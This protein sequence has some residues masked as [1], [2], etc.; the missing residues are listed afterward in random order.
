[1]R[2]HGTLLLCNLLLWILL[3]ALNH[4]LACWQLQILAP[5]L[6]SIFPASRLGRTEGLLSVL[7]AGLIIDASTPVPFGQTSLLLGL[8]H[9]GLLRLRLQV[10]MRERGMQSAVAALATVVI[11]LIQTLL[12]LHTA[13][14][15]A[16]LLPRLGLELFLSAFLAWLIAPWF[17][18]FHE[19]CLALLHANLAEPDEDLRT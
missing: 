6:F 16:A 17:C 9:L 13:P 11:L 7:V 3:G 15:W 2:R 4:A 5:G 19:A 8:L 12:L 10:P 18:A 14:D 1:M